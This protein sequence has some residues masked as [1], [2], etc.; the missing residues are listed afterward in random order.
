MQT[1]LTGRSGQKY[2]FDQVNPS[3]P[4]NPVGAVYAFVNSD[5]WPK[6]IGKTNDLVVRNPGPSHEKWSEAAGFGAT[7]VLAV[8]V[9][10]EVA[11]LAM[12]KDLIQAYQPPAN[13]QHTLASLGAPFGFGAQAHRKTLLGG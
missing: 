3:H 4:Y 2:P 12:E 9:P 5:G 7:R 8:V 13:V 6:Y 10:T 1:I 11:R